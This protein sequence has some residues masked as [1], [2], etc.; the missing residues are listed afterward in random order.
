MSNK[1]ETLDDI[2]TELSGVEVEEVE[3]EEVE[4]EE[5]E[6]EEEATDAKD[7]EDQPEESNEEVNESDS[8][9]E[10]TWESAL[11][12]DEGQLQYDEEGNVSGVNTKV[13]GQSDTIQMK[14]LIVGYQNNKS[15]TQKS[16]ALA[17]E[18]KEFDTNV[19]AIATEYKA[20]LE[21]VEQLTT[22]L[23]DKL[24]Q[25]FDGIDW[26]K[27]RTENPAEYA[28]AR[29]DYSTKA[30]ELQRAQEAIAQEKTQQSEA[31]NAE[32]TQ[33]RQK[34]L[35]EQFEQM[36]SNNPT[37]SNKETLNSDME[38]IKSFMQEQYGF[39][40]NDFAGVDNARVIEVIKDAMAYRKGVKSATIKK[41]VPVPKFQKSKGGSTRKKAS[42]LDT[43]T[44]KAKNASGGARRDA[45]RDAIAELLT[46]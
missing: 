26:D 12:L 29:Q 27:L 44:K 32:Y 1:E 18:R 20:K 38:G 4:T 31:S 34:Y 24:V 10:V 13:N 45:Q 2:A 37:W 16:Q 25:E 9:D 7:D 6:A 21:S 22:F 43:L 39:G 30:S 8:E 15:F 17:E 28:A 19:G 33:G 35:G 42:K 41:A 40:E 23:S 5:V 11:G 46:G 3:T 14:D 36:I